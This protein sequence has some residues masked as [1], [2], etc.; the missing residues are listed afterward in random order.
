MP[1]LQSGSREVKK[2]AEDEGPD[3]SQ[4]VM[5]VAPCRGLSGI[6]LNNFPLPK[7]LFNQLILSSIKKPQDNSRVR[8]KVTLLP[9][10]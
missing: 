6:W 4:A 10:I 7:K 1:V 2:S 9:R 8:I 5:Y 3:E